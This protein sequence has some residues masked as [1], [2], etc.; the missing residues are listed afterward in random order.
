MLLKLNHLKQT[1]QVQLYLQR[2]CIQMARIRCDNSNL[3]FHF[4]QRNS[5]TNLCDTCA[6]PETPYHFFIECA[7]Y[8]R[9]D[10]VK[11]VP[12]DYF[13]INTIFNIQYYT[14]MLLTI[15]IPPYLG[16]HKKYYISWNTAL[17]KDT[18]H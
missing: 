9:R 7:K 6:K 8:D 5:D 10:I 11:S 3:N 15:K 2:Y 13:N 14:L 4:S 18:E 16:A 12:L 17:F 1:H